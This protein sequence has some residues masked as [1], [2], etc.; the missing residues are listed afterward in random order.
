MSKGWVG[1]NQDNTK[2]GDTTAKKTEEKTS[3]GASM[4]L[5]KTSS[6]DNTKQN[7]PSFVSD[8]IATTGSTPT[9]RPQVRNGLMEVPP[10]K[11][12]LFSVSGDLDDADEEDLLLELR[13]VEILQKLKKLRKLK[14][15]YY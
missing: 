11:T 5:E 13:K 10:A 14:L 12:P 7:K 3:N 6:F 15:S 2:K 8:V 1:T 9:G 4:K